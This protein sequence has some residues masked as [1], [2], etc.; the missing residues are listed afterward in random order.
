MKNQNFTQNRIE[1]RSEK[2]RNIGMI[3][4]ALVHWG[5]AIITIII[6]ALLLVLFCAPYPYG[7]GETIFDHLLLINIKIYD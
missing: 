1:I 6:I 5:I 2:V 3:P 7:D 4:P